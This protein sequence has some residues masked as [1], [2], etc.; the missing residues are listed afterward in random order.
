VIAFYRISHRFIRAANS[1]TR[2][3]F[4]FIKNKERQTIPPL[5]IF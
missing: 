4:H 1:T 5:F 2:N 3:I